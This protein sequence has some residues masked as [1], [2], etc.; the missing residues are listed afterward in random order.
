MARGAQTGGCAMQVVLSKNILRGFHLEEGSHQVSNHFFNHY[1]WSLRKKPL[2]VGGHVV[3]ALLAY[4]DGN[5]PRGKEAHLLLSAEE[6]ARNVME[7]T[8]ETVQLV[9]RL[10]EYKV[11]KKK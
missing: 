9:L 4:P 11:F 3:Y 2:I 10:K 5:K 8:E 6:V 1:F 7:H